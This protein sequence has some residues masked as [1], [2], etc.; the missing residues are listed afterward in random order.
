MSTTIDDLEFYLAEVTSAG[1]EPPVRSLVVRLTTD[2]GLEGWGESR[3]E[4][5]AS[6]LPARHA[7]LAP[8][9]AGRSLFEIE[10]L[11]TLPALRFAPLRC[12]VEMASWDLIGRV[13]GQPLCHLFGGGYRRRIPLAVRVASD[14]PEEAARLARELAEQGFHWLTVPSSGHF[15]R[16]VATLAAVRE[17][18]PDRAELY[19]DGAA[20]YDME[21]A[22]DLCAELEAFGLQLVVD[23]LKARDLDQVASLRRQTSVPLGV[24]RAIRAPADVLALVRCGAA[25]FAVVDLQLVGG[26]VPA[27][28]CGTIAQAAAL[29]AALTTGPSLGIGIAAMLQL[30]SAT[31]VFSGC[32]PCAHPHLQDD[33]LVESLEIA[34]GMITV[35][36]GPGLGVEIDRAKLDRRQ[37]RQGKG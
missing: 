37:G 31:P 16:D 23:P 26:L 7:A 27:R 2:R 29:G 9:L 19:F 25:P 20:Q 6:E 4:W 8:V 22:R 15:D 30:A 36:Q 34:E 24:W 18:I 11:L 3:T 28:K 12:A 5:Q 32:N 10:D 17:I 13:T 33:V 35:P 14:R 21:T 1:P